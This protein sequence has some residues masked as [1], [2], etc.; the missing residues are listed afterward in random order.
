MTTQQETQTLEQTLNKTDF[1]HWVNEKRKSILIFGA[2]TLIAILAFSVFNH[3]K[4]SSEAEI[5]D[6][7]Y[8]I[9]AKVFTPFMSEKADAQAFLNEIN[10]MQ[11]EHI[12]H[13][14]LITPFLEVLN[15]LDKNSSLTAKHM[16]VVSKWLSKMDI[17]SDAYLFFAIRASA[18]YENVGNS[19][20]AISILTKL[21]LRNSPLLK[22]QVYFNLGRLSLAKGNTD[23]AVANFDIVIS[24]YPESEFAKLAKIFKGRL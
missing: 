10:S 16:E 4:S 8:E 18:L 17:K 23:S 3:M 14:M 22:D 5:L 9:K 24:Q 1:G 21:S 15:N 2:V 19:N 6:K 12:A 11:N 7:T 13:V 20:E